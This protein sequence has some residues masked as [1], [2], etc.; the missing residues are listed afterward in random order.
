MK[1]LAEL[2]KQVSSMGQL[3]RAWFTSF[4]VDIEFVE[5]YIL[6]AT[7]AVNAPRTRLEYEQLQHALTEKNIDFRVFCDPRFIETHRIKRTCIPVHGIRPARTT[8]YF[9]DASL[10]HPKVIY[11]EDVEG[12]R[13]IG[14]GSA[15]LTVAGWGRNLEVFQFFEVGTDENYRAILAFFTHLCRAADISCALDRKWKP[16][17][18][19]EDWRFVH[20]FQD[21][22]FAQ[23]LLGDGNVGDLLVWSPYLPRDLARFVDS[24]DVAAG[25]AHL[26]IHLVPDRIEGKLR[27]EWRTSLAQ[28]LEQ[29]RLAVYENPAP[30]HPN[31]DLCHAKVWKLQDKVAIGSWN[32][33]GP[34]SNS[35]RDERGNRSLDNNIEAGFIILDGHDLREACGRKLELDAKDFASPALLD[36]ESLQ[37]DP[38]PPFDLHVSFDWREHKYVFCGKW[39]GDGPRDGFSVRLPGVEETVQLTWGSDDFPAQPGE[40]NVDDSALLRD[41]V[42][43]VYHGGREVHR[44]LLQ[45]LQVKARRAQAFDTLQDLLE[46]FVQHDDPG[47]LHD[48]PLRGALD[49]DPLSA[50][51]AAMAES[52]TM[53]GDASLRAGGISYFRLFHSMHAYRLKLSML[54]RLEDLDLHVFSSPGCLLELHD[55]TKDEIKQPGREVFNWFLASEVQALC[56]FALARRH[57]LAGSVGKRASGYAAVPLARWRKLAIDVPAAPAGVHGDYMKLV[58]DQCKYE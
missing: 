14:A 38:L 24:L 18:P 50:A 51:I 39:L 32:F 21:R 42:Y 10:F 8:E 46:A 40:L 25:G 4:S 2:Q 53:S 52:D 29:G 3:C 33:T 48:L 26:R 43:I 30:R 11:L 13:I 47:S 49:N 31:T 35:L 55:K 6:S 12:K 45:E 22:S 36:E 15:N 56:K 44:A 19:S 23:Q 57:E 1:L 54:K 28:M 34:G 58:M 7:L 16:G 20:S 37:V 5:T 17:G 27:T 41:R 9:S